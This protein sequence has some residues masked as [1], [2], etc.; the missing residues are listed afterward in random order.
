MY[1]DDFA[2]N[3][4]DYIANSGQY[5]EEGNRLVLNTESNGRFHTDWLNMIYP[6]L[7]LAKDLLTEDGAIFV[8]IDDNEVERLTAVMN[9]IFG[10]ENHV[11]TIVWDKKSSAKGVPPKSMMV[12]VHEYI[13]VFQKSG[14]FSF[15][16]EKRDEK[17]DGFKNPGDL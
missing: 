12:N 17:N 3:V 5:D 15:S 1:N 13:V 4:D 9:E 11:E 7:K 6:R 14:G 16:G 2:E 10:E 8:S